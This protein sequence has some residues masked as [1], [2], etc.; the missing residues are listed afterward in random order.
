MSNYEIT[1]IGIP[2]REIDVTNKFLEVVEKLKTSKDAVAVLTADYFGDYTNNYDYI[3]SPAGHKILTS[4]FK[5]QKCNGT[6]KFNLLNTY[7]DLWKIKK[8]NISREPNAITDALLEF[9]D[10]QH[11]ILNFKEVYIFAPGSPFV[12][13]MFTSFIP[14][15][16]AL[17]IIDA[18]SSIHISAD[19]MCEYVNT[20]KVAIR[21]YID[22]FINKK[23]QVLRDGINV[24][25]GVSNKYDHNTGIP[26][27][28]HFFQELK[29][30]LDSDDVFMY[31]SINDK[32]VDL[33][34]LTFKEAEDKIDY[35]LN[36]NEILTYGV[37]KKNATI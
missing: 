7:G 21:S 36:T 25:G 27:I 34:V 22:D 2:I 32:D 17:N 13:D 20:P 16:R 18:R 26:M 23:Y 30:L 35:F 24:F 11:N 28:S 12:L 37:A 3:S 4:N 8:D 15:R 29:K 1:K 19:A 9:L 31:T 5:L 10:A 33:K 14:K 6:L